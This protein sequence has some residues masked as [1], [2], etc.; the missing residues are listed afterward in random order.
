MR[1]LITCPAL[2]SALI[3]ALPNAA[4]ATCPTAKSDLDKGIHLTS[5]G[6]QSIRYRRDAQ[7]HVLVEDFPLGDFVFSYLATTMFGIYPLQE[8]TAYLGETMPDSLASM[9]FAVPSGNLPE[10]TPG[11]A[12]HSPVQISGTEGPGP[13]LFVSVGQPQQ[14]NFGD[15]TYETL[16]VLARMAGQTDDHLS[17][18]H[19]IPA[20]G[21]A[22]EWMSGAFDA[23]PQET[24]AIRLSL[25]P[26]DGMPAP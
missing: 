3:L 10:P 14:T 22:M 8:G 1:I 18:F 13:L 19:Y 5:D 17:R 21:F 11:L 26:P 6:P 9:A 2:I 15:C 4:F 24:S 25:V 23:A 12:F 20:L 16:P 7:G